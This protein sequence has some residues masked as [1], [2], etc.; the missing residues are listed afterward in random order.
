MNL[1]R[2]QRVLGV[3]LVA[4]C[5]WVSGQSAAHG[6]IQYTGSISTP[7]DLVLGGEW[8]TGSLSW[9]VTDNMNGTW[10]YSYTFSHLPAD[11]ETSHYTFEISANVNSVDL[12][13]NVQ[14]NF[15]SYELGQ[16][17]GNS[18][19]N[20]PGDF[21]NALKF[22]FNDPGDATV[23]FDI[24]RDPT[25]GDF[26]SKGG[27]NQNLGT[28][29]NSGFVAGDANDP[30]DAPS[31]GPHINDSGLAHILV[32]DSVT[33]GGIGNAELPEA[34]SLIVWSL[35]MGAVGLVAQ[36]RRQCIVD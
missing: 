1:L 29:W 20:I 36:R 35:L 28:A 25:W 11:P 30:L 18:N 31:D 33:G 15:T 7:T 32:P 2:W 16:G 8:L 3:T 34:A 21:T 5:V 23:S 6:S 26:Y 19:P 14:G 9:I 4:L 10:N 12:F 17:G 24:A 13:T 27:N 22:N